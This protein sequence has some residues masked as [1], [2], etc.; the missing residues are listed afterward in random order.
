MEI[1]MDNILHIFNHVI[2][3]LMLVWMSKMTLI[4]EIH[5]E[6]GHAE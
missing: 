5:L 3:Q 2:K 4:I 1:N 6:Y